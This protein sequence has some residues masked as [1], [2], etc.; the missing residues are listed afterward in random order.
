[1]RT[2]S[3]LYSNEQLIDISRDFYRALQ[4]GLQDDKQPIRCLPTYINPDFGRYQGQVYVLDLGGSNLRAARVELTEDGAI[5]ASEV[6]EFVMPWLRGEIFSKADYL[7]CLARAIDAVRINNSLPLAFCFSF[8]CTSLTSGDAVLNKWTKGLFVPDTEG[9]S[10]TQDLLAL[11]DSEYQLAISG[12][13]IV[14]DTVA[15]LLAGLSGNSDNVDVSFGGYLGL[16]AG[17]GFNIATMMQVGEV[18]KLENASLAKQ[19]PIPINLECGNHK[20]LMLA[21][22]DNVLDA[23][24]EL[25]G[26]Q[27]LEKACASMYLARLFNI[28]SDDVKVDA[29]EGAKAFSAVVKNHGIDSTPGQIATQLYERSAQ[30]TACS[31]V[32]N[33]LLLS[34]SR[35]IDSIKVV[36][37]GGLFW[38]QLTP[39]HTYEHLTQNYI[40]QL[41]SELGLDTEFVIKRVEHANLLGS[42][43]ALNLAS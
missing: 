16:I 38:S 17:T 25:P 20:P 10:V 37:E 11:L 13:Q 30:L 4:L 9:Q 40:K 41:V 27:Q 1:M 15:S 39:Q 29:S 43:M 14:N 31:L 28:L 32:A 33:L 22:C 42:A 8:P 24:S 36:A 12:V 5:L 7:H 34:D 23:A 26:Q 19:Q 3:L 21:D 6:K 2:A 18:A 35:Q